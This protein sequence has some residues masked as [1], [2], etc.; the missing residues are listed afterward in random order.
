MERGKTIF[1]FGLA[2]N[3]ELSIYSQIQTSIFVPNIQ[4]MSFRHLETFLFMEQGTC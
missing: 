2:R 4:L 3:L 1:I